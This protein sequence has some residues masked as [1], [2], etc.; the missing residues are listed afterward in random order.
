MTGPR[1]GRGESSASVRR[2]VLLLISAMLPCT[3][4]AGT[5]AAAELPPPPAHVVIVIDENKTL[6]Q[7]AGSPHAPVLNRLIAR[8]ALFTD[9]HGVTHPSLPNYFALF[10]GR[11][12]TNGDG[13]PATGIPADA[14]NLAT[15]MFGLGKTFT[16]YAE[17]MPSVGFRG[18][19]AGTYARKHVPWVQFTNVP[20]A[21]SRPLADLTS[22]DRLGT[23]AMIVPDVEDDMHDGTIA[24]GDAWAAHWLAPLVAWADRND[25]LVVV[26][27]DE[28]Y[29]PRNDIPTFFLGPMVKPGRYPE[30]VDHYRVLR[31]IEALYRLPP[32]G[33]AARTTPITDCW[34]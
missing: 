15:Q 23:L 8:G 16:G 7:I 20:A 4:G 2:S 3:L 17:A 29:D 30:R 13:C 21:D 14:P 33:A 27:W 12:N 26:T 6:A 10:S 11:T 19:W 1:R 28:G 5:A 24:Q 18:C 31:T 32:L 22:Y 34:R 9:A 25:A